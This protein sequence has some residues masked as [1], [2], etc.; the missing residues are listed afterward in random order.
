M[1]ALKCL[2]MTDVFSAVIFDLGGVVVQ[3]QPRTVVAQ[4]TA[5]PALRAALLANVFEHP[6]WAEIDRGALDESTAI[7]R[8]QARLPLADGEYEKL[9]EAA[10]ASL[11]PIPPTLSL[12]KRLR[13]LGVPL[14]VLS[15]MPVARFDMLRA[16]Y[17]FWDSFRDF[18]ISGAIGLLKPQQEIFEYALSRFACHPATTI[19]VD[20]HAANVAA[21]QR[22]GL[23]TLLYRDPT[24]GAAELAGLL[25]QVG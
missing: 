5:D 7:A 19:F 2:P 25:K 18:V 8:M 20:D 10:D 22:L 6:D 17:D 15:N 9:L 12:I 16:R 3:W 1:Q 24:S 13:A 11:T 23:R 21:A 14:F 4:F